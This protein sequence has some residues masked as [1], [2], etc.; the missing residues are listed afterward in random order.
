MSDIQLFLDKNELLRTEFEEVNY[1]EFYRDIFPVG[2]FERK[3]RYDDEKGNGIALNI[4]G[5]HY[6]RVTITDDLDAIHDLVKKD[7][8]I[9][10]GISYFGRERTMYNATLMYAMVFDIDGI[11]DLN[12]LHNL[13]S[14]TYNGEVRINP[15]P[16]YIVNSGHGVHLYY[17]FKKP[18]PLYNHLKEPLKNLKYHFTGRLWNMYV[19]DIEEVQYQGLNQAFRMV[20]SPTKFGK[21]YRLTAFRVGEK[22]DL[23]YFNSYLPSDRQDLAVKTINYEPKLTL[24]EAKE[25]Y[26]EWYERRIIQKQKSRTWTVKRDLYDWWIRKIKEGAT[27]GH[28]YFCIMSLAIYAAKCEIPYEELEKDAFDLL[29]F[30]NSLNNKEPFTKVDI[31]S[32]LNSYSEEFKTFPRKDIE[33]ITAI[34]IPKNKR[35]GQKQNEHLE[36]ARAIRDIRMSRLGRTW[37]GNQSKEEE[38]KKYILKNPNKSPTEISNEIKV[39]RPTVYKYLKQLEQKK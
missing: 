20:G 38:V 22:V 39:S 9:M 15:T 11:S 1:E 4:K 32:A 34:E 35:N 17:V 30:L 18:I 10:N 6:E 3:G 25:K 37:Q 14:H 19:S 2:S 5:E 33:K 8:V 28:R 16:T 31:L 26:P 24:E 12:K 27:Y 36:E 7:F 29:P 13:L 21:D 23:E